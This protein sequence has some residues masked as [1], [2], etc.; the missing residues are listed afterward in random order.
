MGHGVPGIG[1]K[2]HEDL[3]Y[4]GNVEETEAILVGQVHRKADVLGQQLFSSFAV[5]ATTPFTLWGSRAIRCLRLKARRLRVS[6]AALS[7]EATIWSTCGLMNVVLANAHLHEVA[8]A[9]DDGEN[10][11]EVMGDAAGEGAHGFHLL[12]L[13]QFLTGTLQVGSRSSTKASK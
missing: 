6:S 3:A 12:G 4:L 1:S 9:H 13:T 10:V 8:Q 11:V 5:L 2:V 7:D